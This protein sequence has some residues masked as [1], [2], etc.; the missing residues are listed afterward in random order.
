MAASEGR[1]VLES[2]KTGRDHGFVERF[3]PARLFE[4]PPNRLHPDGYG[5]WIAGT[6][7]VVPASACGF[8][9]DDDPVLV[10]AVRGVHRAYAWHMLK[11]HTVSDV[12][13]G[14]SVAVM[15]CENCSSG[16]V[17]DRTVAGRELTFYTAGAYN[18]TMHVRDEQQGAWWAPPDGVALDG[19]LRGTVL[20]WYPTWHMSFAEFRNLHPDGEVRTWD[21]VD[22]GFHRDPR[23]GHGSDVLPGSAGIEPM[24]VATWTGDGSGAF[25]ERLRENVLGLAINEPGA[26]RFYPLPDVERDG[27]VTHDRIDD[28]PVAVLS[29]QRSY[30]MA[31]YETGLD[32]RELRFHRDGSGFVDEQ[33]GSRWTI[34]GLAV[35]GPLAGRRLTPFRWQCCEWHTWVSAHPDTE[36]RRSTAPPVEDT[37]GNPAFAA[38]VTALRDAGFTLDTY[39]PLPPVWSAESATD[40]LRVVID[41][42]PLEV[43][44][45]ADDGDAADAL[46]ADAHA[47]RLG[48]FVVRSD[49]EE[50]FSNW[51]QTRPLRDKRIAWSKLLDD[52]RFIAVVGRAL[53]PHMGDVARPA[54]VHELVSLLAEAGFAVRT[55]GRRL[56]PGRTNDAGPCYVCQV[57]VG[58]EDALRIVVDGDCFLVSR[59]ADESGA[60][61]HAATAPHCTLTAGRLV[62]RSDPPGQYLAPY[63]LNTYDAPVE[64]V[65][66]SRLLDDARFR[67]VCEELARRWR[68]SRPA[69]RP[70][71]DGK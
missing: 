12:V 18:C 64:K 37:G 33:T 29:P 13:S 63:P 69:G 15:F 45:F 9:R 67:A 11:G 39:W 24:F 68:A 3:D 42:D 59:F 6:S 26:L 35:D 36:I 32:G 43:L 5:F 66:W 8:L 52:K 19:P 4:L 50:Q 31:M 30:A 58:A 21:D 61:A 55:H 57:P 71:V 2:A 49:P 17:Y 40:T 70:R 7:E 10:T 20:D 44:E 38:L 62:L 34:E 47:V 51:P 23:H 16:A 28:R 46:L 60:A 14:L 41:G 65:N 27:G 53:A 1:P 54:G 48:S 56:N 25:D 22:A